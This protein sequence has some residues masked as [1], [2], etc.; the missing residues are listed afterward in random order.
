MFPFHTAGLPRSR[1][2]DQRTPEG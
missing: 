1:L 2:W